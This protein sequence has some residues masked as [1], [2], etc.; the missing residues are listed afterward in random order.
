M[1]CAKT[2]YL[3]IQKDEAEIA[4]VWIS[5]HLIAHINYRPNRMDESLA[6]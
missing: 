1:A 4:G 3:A 5:L 2:D 6:S